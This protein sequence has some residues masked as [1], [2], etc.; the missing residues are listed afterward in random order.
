MM[1]V[2]QFFS[3]AE[4]KG[5][6]LVLNQASSLKRDKITFWFEWLI[7]SSC[8]AIPYYHLQIIILGLYT[9]ALSVMLLDFNTN[10]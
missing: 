8:L 1:I 5:L 6:C 10:D 4:L 3:L 7:W 2:L 9:V